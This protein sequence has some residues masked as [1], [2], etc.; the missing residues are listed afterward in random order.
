MQRLAA[1]SLIL[2]GSKLAHRF[3][4]DTV[5]VIGS[6]EPYDIGELDPSGIDVPE[7]FRA[8]ALE[9][10]AASRK[11][12][13]ARAVLYRG[14]MYRP[15]QQAMFSFVPA[16]AGSRPFSRPVIESAGVLDRMVNPDNSRSAKAT[17]VEAGK[18]EAVWRDVVE[19]V[20]AQGLD[21]AVFLAEPKILP[22]GTVLVGGELA[23]CT[24][25]PARDD[26]RTG[27]CL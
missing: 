21:L 8:A 2:F 3:V 5:M 14:A 18:A 6:A 15:G 17:A 12:A 25:L 24:A 9:P 22:G 13:G 16:S 11:L 26:R 27:A 4:L 20:R 7:V 1:G 23:G 19:Q 10:L